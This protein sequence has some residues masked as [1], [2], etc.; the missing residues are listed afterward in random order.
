MKLQE[1]CVEC[2]AKRAGRLLKGKAQEK[3][4]RLLVEKVR[5][6]AKK[7]VGKKSPV[8]QAKERTELIVKRLGIVDVSREKKDSGMKTAKR[9]VRDLELPKG[10]LERF[11]RLVRIVIAANSLELDLPG[12]SAE[13][14]EL[15]KRFKSEVDAP[16][17][18]D[19]SKE[20]YERILKSKKI[21]YLC[22]NAPELVF[23]LLLIR[24]LRSL[25]KKV[26][27]VVRG[28][29]TQDDA[30]PREARMAGLEGYI[31]TGSSATGVVYL[32]VTKKLQVLLRNSDLIIAKGMGNFEGLTEDP[33]LIKNKTAFL[34]KVKCAP[35]AREVG[36]PK[37]SGAAFICR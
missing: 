19:E 8:I 15:E 7:N 9:I 33:W 26:T 34:F 23:D 25:G 29:F 24:F 10:R 12:H 5:A 17:G 36:V 32:D 18:L 11:K 20:I 13:V 6:S 21:L 27:P 31:T 16:L 35:V 1:E 2:S 30:T 3:D 22:D 14:G 4:I 28:R 37:G